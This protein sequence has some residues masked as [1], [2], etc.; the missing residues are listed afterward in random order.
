M[1]TARWG[2]MVDFFSASM[3]LSDA[4]KGV[5]AQNQVARLVAE[6][7]FIAGCE[8]AERTAYAHLG[9]LLL[10][11][12]NPRVFG[13]G[14][15]DTLEGRL[16]TISGFQGGDRRIIE[17]GMKLLALC[18]LGDHMRDAAFDASRGKY[19]PINAGVV[20]ADAEKERLTR[21]IEAVRCPEMD[22]IMQPQDVILVFW[23]NLAEPVANDGVNEQSA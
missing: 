8:Q 3:G 1:D 11:A 17:R 5:L 23:I 21:E 15:S 9:T 20:N 22:A 10:A 6:L 19:N 18:S 16:F 14:A 7:P 12:R 4:Q 2:Q 13:H